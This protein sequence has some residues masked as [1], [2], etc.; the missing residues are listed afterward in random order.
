MQRTENQFH[1]NTFQR[2]SSIG[3]EPYGSKLLGDKIA[4]TPHHRDFYCSLKNSKEK[5]AFA[6]GDSLSVKLVTPKDG[7]IEKLDENGRLKPKD[8]K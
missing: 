5:P 1:L 7:N 6:Y 2:K 8:D 3:I 4:S